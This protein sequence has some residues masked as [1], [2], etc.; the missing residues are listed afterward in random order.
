MPYKTKFR[1]IEMPQNAGELR[2]VGTDANSMRSLG[3]A[4]YRSIGQLH[5]E[6]QM[7]II[8]DAILSAYDKV[9]TPSLMAE[10][11]TTQLPRERKAHLYAMEGMQKAAERA[12]HSDNAEYIAQALKQ[13]KG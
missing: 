7:R 3:A 10:G 11:R 4:A 13:L 6:E 1:E 8:T 9:I 2:A 5:T 12:G